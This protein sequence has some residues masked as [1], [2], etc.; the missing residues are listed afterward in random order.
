[1]LYE[2]IQ[3]IGRDS[4]KLKLPARIGSIHPVFHTS[5]L[6]P[7]SN[8]PLQGQHIA[9]Q[10]PILVQDEEHEEEDAYKEWE[11]EEIVDSRYSYGFLEYKVKWKG[12][13]MERRKWYRA[14]LFTN[15]A[16][17]LN[18]FYTKYPNKL[19]PRQDRLRIRQA[20]LDSRVQERNSALEKNLTL[21]RDARLALE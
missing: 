2:I 21:R 20:D 16:E 3:R 10:P 6:H 7:D 13:P 4:Y 11:V 8:D 15:A 12:H 9:P 17:V 19:A 14:H 1:M 18:D 5:L